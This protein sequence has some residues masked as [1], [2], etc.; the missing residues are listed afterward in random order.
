MERRTRRGAR[1]IVRSIVRSYDAFDKGVLVDG[2]Y[3]WPY[4][5]CFWTHDDQQAA[6]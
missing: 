4:H 1:K 6:C 5:V 3:A 2:Q